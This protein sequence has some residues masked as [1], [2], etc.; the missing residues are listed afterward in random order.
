MYHYIG[1]NFLLYY[2]FSLLALSSPCLYAQS[3][4]M[5]HY[6]TKDGLPGNSL[7]ILHQDTDG[8][9]WIA[10]TTGITRFDGKNFKTYRKEDSILVQASIIV[11]A[12]DNNLWGFTYLNSS[13]VNISRGKVTVYRDSLLQNLPDKGHKLNK[14]VYAKQ[15]QVAYIVGRYSLISI[16]NGKKPRYINTNLEKAVTTFEVDDGKVFIS[17]GSSFYKIDDTTITYFQTLD[18]DLPFSYASYYN[19]FLYTCTENIIRVYK[20][21]NNGFI[22]VNEYFLK[23]KIFRIHANEHGLWIAHYHKKAI[24]LYAHDD[25]YFFSKTIE[26]E[27]PTLVNH[28][29]SD[30]NG[31]VWI[32]SFNSG[33]IY[34]PTPSISSFSIKN[35]LSDQTVYALE[36][37]S[38][39]KI[40]LG[41]YSGMVELS[42]IQNDTIKNIQKFQITDTLPGYS[43][44]IDIIKR[45]ESVYILSRGKIFIW[46]NGVFKNIKILSSSNK[47]LYIINDTVLSIGSMSQIIHNRNQLTRTIYNIGRVYTQAMDSSGNLYLGGVKGLFV[48]TNTD[49]PTIRKIDIIKGAEIKAN[50]LA[51]H[52]PYIWVGTVSNGIFLMKGDSVVRRY[53]TQNLGIQSLYSSSIVLDNNEV[54]VGTD[55][56]IFWGQFDYDKL[57]FTKSQQ[58][59]SNDGLPGEDIIIIKKNKGTVFVTSYNGGLTILKDLTYKHIYYPEPEVLFRNLNTNEQL[60]QDS[61]NTTYSKEGLEL[62]FTAPAFRYNNEISYKYKLMPFHGDWRTTKNNIVQYTNIP[63]GKYEF[64]IE[65]VDTRPNTTSSLSTTYIYVAPLYWQTTWFK[66]LIAIALLFVIGVFFNW[67]YKRKKKQEIEAL[68]MQQQLAKYRM[69]TLKAHLKPHFIFNSLSSIKD[70]I[71]TNNNDDVADLLQNFV[72]LIRNGL[73]LADS[74]FVSVKNEV[75]FIKRYLEL[76]RLKCEG[77]FDY[78]IEVSPDI[79]NIQIPCLITQPFVENAVIHGTGTDNGRAMININYKISGQNLICEI[80]DNGIGINRSMKRIGSVTSRGMNISLEQVRHIKTALNVDIEVIIQDLSELNNGLTGT[81]VVIIM[82]NIIK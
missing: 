56:G 72:G 64:L 2:L 60:N 49:S 41:Y 53:N 81:K 48:Y 26:I 54:L 24:S 45:G 77:C 76:E 16:P 67:Y 73:Q 22:F 50:A 62:V 25:R 55:K 27:L 42:K 70:Y 74:D 23:E 57:E 19:G 3:V 59:N 58:I 15:T 20:Y 12:A 61:I 14:A 51:L 21:T 18:T 43:F 7:T 63:P 40:W 65:V 36:V 39:N 37:D 78:V 79:D 5:K 69:E 71:Y 66:L 34:I 38:N 47:S 29:I 10:T 30:K 35:G 82:K 32:G 6:T 46:E 31:G 33:L 52:S 11:N 28:I 17:N 68:R 8:Y 9:I 44:I 4:Y 1:K 75:I 13:L 80:I